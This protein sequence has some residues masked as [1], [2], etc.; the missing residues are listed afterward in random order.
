MD[1]HHYH[2]KQYNEAF[3]ERYLQSQNSKMNTPLLDFFQNIPYRSNLTTA[4]QK[5]ISG[6]EEKTIIVVEREYRD[7]YLPEDDYC[8]RFFNVNNHSLVFSV[9]AVSEEIRV[10]QLTEEILHTKEQFVANISHEIRTPLNGILGYIAMLS[11]AS[12]QSRLTEYQKNCL[13]Q[14]RECSMNLLYIM[15]DILDFSKLNADQMKLRSEPFDIAECLEQSYDIILPGAQEKGLK[16]AFFI[17]PD[18]PPRIKGDFKKLRQILLN[19]LSN[20]VKFTNRGRIDT[21]VSLV[22][23]DLTNSEMDRDG[24]YTIQFTVED[25]GIGI[26]KQDMCKLF[27]SFSQID[28]SS[29]KVYQ[30]TGLGLIISKKIIELMQGKITV[31]SKEGNGTK[32]IFTIKAEEARATSADDSEELLPLLK[33]ISVLVV[34]DHVTNRMTIAS[35]LVKWGMK[36]FV[37]GSSEE[38]LLYLR[39]GL[40]KIDLALIDMRMPVMDGNELAEKIRQIEPVMP[41]VSITSAPNMKLSEHF[42]H[43]V[44]KP[45]KTRQLFNI[46]ISIVRKLRMNPSSFAIVSPAMQK[47]PDR[48]PSLLAKLDPEIQETENRKLSQHYRIPENLCQRLER[49]ILVAEDLKTNQNV[50]IALLEKMGFNHSNI[51][52]CDNGKTT[53]EAIGKKHFDI[54]LMD[55]KMPVIDGFDAT[56]RIRKLYKSGPRKDFQ[57]SPFIIAVTAN[58]TSGI[59][60]KCKEVGMN[61]YISKPI[62]IVELAKILDEAP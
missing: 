62:N 33:D 26:R 61:A 60:D 45:I 25:T 5:I 47:M 4:I 22:K 17:S 21:T 38:A 13:D 23:D 2:C 35:T 49:N 19:L 29:S 36:P 27:K 8:F 32:F 20:G 55:L 41:L 46:C 44:M 40:L 43:R 3:Q 52:V 30:G 15:N 31:E 6:T 39:G 18:V 48:K 1:M 34:D 24:L 53:L 58:A 50:I 56:R 14:I 12:E 57:R 16:A 28:Q 42:A 11:D 37:C 59:T 7:V 54:I 10:E 9:E 51:M